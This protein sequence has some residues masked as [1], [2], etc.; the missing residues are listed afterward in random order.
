MVTEELHDYISKER[1]LGKNQDEIK[2]VL[3]SEGWKEQDIAEVFNNSRHD[4][5]SKKN[6][7]SRITR[8]NILILILAISV[9]IFTGLYIAV[10]YSV[11]NNLSTIPDQLTPSPG[12]YID[13]ATISHKAEIP[14]LSSIQGGDCGTENF[15]INLSGKATGSHPKLECFI[16]NSKTCKTSSIKMINSIDASGIKTESTVS[17]RI[18]K[19]D[20]G[21]KLDINQGKISYTLPVGVPEDL[22]DPILAPIKKLENTS[23]VCIFSNTNDLVRVFEK[24]NKG[25]FSMYLASDIKGQAKH[26]EMYISGSCSGKYF[27]VFK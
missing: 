3:L 21:C 4:A 14:T 12:S 22:L 1:K 27:D 6:F 17:Y 19:M 25:D 9:L 13:E 8:K 5:E 2:K 24:L 15:V 16:N 20:T 26:T 18:E 7:F 11:R 10:S 23:G